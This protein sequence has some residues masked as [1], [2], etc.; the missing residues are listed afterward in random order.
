M[1]SETPDKFFGRT[2]TTLGAKASTV[3]NVT[4]EVVTPEDTGGDSEYVDSL[5]FLTTHNLHPHRDGAGSK[6]V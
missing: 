6:H 3:G 1:L 2:T 5:Y 4:S